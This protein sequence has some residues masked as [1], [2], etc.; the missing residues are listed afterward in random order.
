MYS[1]FSRSR[2]EHNRFQLIFY[3]AVFFF[4][5]IVG[6]LVWLQIIHVDEYRA[7]ADEQNSRGVVLPARRGNIYAKDYRTGELFPLAQNSTTYTIFADPALIDSGTE[8]AVVEQILPFLFVEP[9]EEIVPIKNENAEPVVAVDPRV[10]FKNK[11]INQLA[12]KDVVRREIHSISPEELQIVAESHLPGVGIDGEIVTINPNLIVDPETVA[13]QLATI[14]ATDYTDIY[15]LLLP[16]KVRYIR[17]ATRVIPSVRDE[18][19]ALDIRGIGSIAEYRRVYP[20]NNLASQVIGFLNHDEKGEY[21]IEGAFDSK[22]S[23]KNGLRQTQQDPFGRQITVGK[24]L[25]ENA[26]DG[27]SLVLTID[28]SIQSLVEDELAKVVDEQRA[29]SGQAIVMD[30]ATGAILALAHYPSFDPNSY[31]A[32]YSTEELIKKERDWKWVDDAG[33]VHDE[34]EEWWETTDGI[35]AV[36]EWGVE[37]VVR[38]GYRYPTFTEYRDGEPL[39]KSIYEN[40]LG[41]GVFA[42]KSATDPY[43][44]GSVFKSVVMAAAIDAGEVTPMTRSP[45]SG[46]VPLDEINY[47]T[48]KP[49]VIKNSQGLYHGQETMTEVLAN[50]SNIGMTFVAQKLGAATFYDYLRKF[51]F[52]E[53]TEVEFEGEDA[54]LLENYTKWS[55]SELATKGFGQGINVNLFQ[56]AAAYSALAN[57]GLLMKPF[58]VDE[59]ISSSGVRI[60]TEPETIRR[61]IDEE[62]SRT[63]TEMLVNS[64][65]VGYAKSGGVKG[66]FVAGKTGTSQTYLNGIAL[67]AVGTTIATF[68]GYAPATNPK[69]I[70][71]VKVD[72]PRIEEWGTTSAAPVF[73]KVTEELLTNYF[74]IPPNE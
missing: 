46:P 7:L 28:R 2:R 47:R 45:Y 21:G 32:V 69:F 67:T 72:R 9:A 60:K 6:K 59:E 22:L 14:L 43:E 29:D 74:A 61:V 20:E 24:V 11:L 49:I 3:V 51:G 17:L 13:T 27:D 30:P 55:E 4:A 10:E 8:A 37:Y 25:I 35:R 42:L 34:H 39:R 31:G 15:P 57:G 53:R 62:T 63:I 68:G 33:A 16:K 64:V 40:R 44:P 18:I 71:L 36:E 50:S 41:E 19:A 54:G 23:G 5:V 66:Y 70:V 73:Q 65:S 48:R 56:M 52:D 12:T 38:N 26:E 58:I 1:N